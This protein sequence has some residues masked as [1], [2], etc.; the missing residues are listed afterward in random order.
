MPG[1]WLL[2]DIHSFSRT[3]ALAA[4]LPELGVEAYISLRIMLVELD[5]AETFHLIFRE[6]PL[7]LFRLITAR[8]LSHLLLL[9]RFPQGFPPFLTLE[10]GLFILD[11]FQNFIGLASLPTC[12]L[13]PY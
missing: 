2:F 3:S 6:V 4:G 8:G 13:R 5:T 11:V 10:Q 1:S 12:S 9:G 7:R